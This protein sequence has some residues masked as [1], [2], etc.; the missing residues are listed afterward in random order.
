MDSFPLFREIS[1]TSYS[2]SSEDNASGPFHRA[3]ES[4][5]LYAVDITS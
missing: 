3:D 5:T 2:F 4:L 1:E